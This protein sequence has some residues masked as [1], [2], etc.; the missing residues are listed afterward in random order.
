MPQLELDD[1]QGLYY[2]YDAPRDG[3]PCFVFVNAITGNAAAWQAEI[4]PALRAEGFGTLVYNLRGQD[5]S[6]FD[7]NIDLIDSLIVEDL[8]RLMERLA[9]PR[10]VYVGLSIGGLFAARAH[11]AGATAEA[12]VLINTLRVADQRLD[13]ISRAMV[14]AVDQGGLPLLLDL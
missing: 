10:P 1:R 11:L 7:P 9:P 14:R 13:W 3:Q 12:L 2:E 4:G 5:E 8:C 6:P